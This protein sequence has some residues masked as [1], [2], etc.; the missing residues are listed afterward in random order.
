MRY[1]FTA[2]GYDQADCPDADNI[3]LQAACTKHLGQLVT[4]H[5]DHFGQQ[6][7]PKIE[8][9]LVKQSTLVAD[10]LILSEEFNCTWPHRA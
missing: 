7:V 4:S 6:Q 2:A 3:M 9:R 1:Y 10:L 5:A 8:R